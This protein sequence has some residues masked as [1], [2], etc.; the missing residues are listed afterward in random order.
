MVANFQANLLTDN[1]IDLK[2]FKLEMELSSLNHLLKISDLHGKFS[3]VLFAVQ[4]DHGI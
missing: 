2:Q 4:I 1:G 3:S